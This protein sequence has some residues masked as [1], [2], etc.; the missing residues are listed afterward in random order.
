MNQPLMHN[1]PA[2]H[3][4]GALETASELAKAGKYGK[5]LQLLLV[6]LRQDPSNVR[7]L[8]LTATCYLEIGD[9]QTAV[10]LLELLADSNPVLPQA[11]GK[12]A[13]VRATSGDKAGAVQAFEQALSL[14]PGDV[15]LLAARNRLEPFAGERSRPAAGGGAEHRRF[16]ARPDPVAFRTGRD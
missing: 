8:D 9:S 5:A 2:Q 1:T 10:R 14:A 4:A 13:A 7:V 15:G 3:G 16:S 11:W 6:L 12:L